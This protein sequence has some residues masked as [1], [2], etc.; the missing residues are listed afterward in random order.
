MLKI[1]V[2]ASYPVI[3]WAIH[4]A[5]AITLTVQLCECWRF[6]QYAT[7]MFAFS[8]WHWPIGKCW[9]CKWGGL[10]VWA[11]PMMSRRSRM[12]GSMHSR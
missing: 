2:M 9:T 1:R 3:A 6:T 12:A 4:S 10:T 8:L 7:L 11:A 5:G